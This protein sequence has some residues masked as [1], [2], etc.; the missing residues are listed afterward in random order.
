ME[1]YVKVVMQYGT[2]RLYPAC[3]QAE[4][5]TAIAGT[6]T[7]SRDNIKNIKSLGYKINEVSALNSL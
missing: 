2:E 3:K 1:I 5:F 4:H 7:L 6:K